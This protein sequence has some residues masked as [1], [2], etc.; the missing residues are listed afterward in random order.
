MRVKMNDIKSGSILTQMNIKLIKATVENAEEIYRMQTEAFKGL[1]EKYQDFE[2]SPANENIERTIDRIKRESAV[3][4]IIKY[5]QISVGGVW[6]DNLENG[7]K[8]RISRLFVI[9]EYQ[10]KKIAQKVFGILEHE[11]K[12]RS[13][14]YLDTILQERGNCYLYE[15]MGYKRVGE[16]KKINEKMD[17]VSYEKRTDT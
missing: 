14:W 7:S 16:V 2:T 10:N 8:C 11:Y 6:V 12:P 4:Y 9:P 5:E 3:F 15:K 13:G 1:L 17:I